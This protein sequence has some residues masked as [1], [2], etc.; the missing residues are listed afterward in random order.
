VVH[1]RYFRFDL[2]VNQPL[3]KE[4][5]MFLMGK[6]AKAVLLSL[7][8]GVGMLASLGANAQ[9]TFRLSLVAGG[10]SALQGDYRL[11]ANYAPGAMARVIEQLVPITG[12]KAANQ[13]EQVILIQ[14]KNLTDFNDVDN[15]IV[16]YDRPAFLGGGIGKEVVG[17]VMIRY[18][19]DAA[20]NTNILVLVRSDSGQGIRYA[21]NKARI[22]RLP[23][24]A[25]Q[26][27]KVTTGTTQVA[28]GIGSAN[29]NVSGGGNV[30]TYLSSTA[31]PIQIDTGLSDTAADSAI[32]YVPELEVDPTGVGGTLIEQFNLPVITLLVL[33]NNNVHTQSGT[34]FKLNITKTQFRNII[35]GAPDLDGG[36]LKWS[37]I[38]PRLPSFALTGVYRE[39]SSG[40][41][42][43]QLLGVQRV[44]YSQTL[45][46]NQY[47]SN[48]NPGSNPG[49]T[50]TVNPNPQQGTGRML[51][52]INNGYNPGTTAGST[53]TAVL[54][55]SFVTGNAG[56]G[57][58][59]TRV[60]L[61]NGV[62]PFRNAPTDTFAATD[63]ASLAVPTAANYTTFSSTG[64]PFYTETQN[65]RYELWT[66]P[67]AIQR[68]S[69]QGAR[70]P[71]LNSIVTALNTNNPLFQPIV[72]GAGF[73]QLSEMRAFRAGFIS[74][75]TGEYVTDGQL[76]N[77][78]STTTY[79]PPAPGLVVTDPN[80][81]LQ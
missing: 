35:S 74:P 61:Y 58:A 7:G 69:L 27:R 4:I 80:G 42:Q 65:G 3:S 18:V 37:T 29:V 25:A 72:D 17:D 73:V 13:Q 79:N 52:T 16:E 48:I 23:A 8:L 40:T 71:T 75:I 76:V 30:L 66:V 78:D 2:A 43:T 41:R 15:I 19:D 59:N 12:Y 49:F 11:D 34:N 47:F 77:Y 20:N 62:A 68:R 67:V 26:Y 14:S 28:T 70:R 10:S 44:T 46:E 63:G 38:D 51:Q 21:A 22:V 1:G 60:A 45:V 9:T 36:P 55:Y 57:R 56:A 5:V 6:K 53:Q 24:A 81:I 54:G 64:I 39:N 50:S 33:Y 32:R 31:L